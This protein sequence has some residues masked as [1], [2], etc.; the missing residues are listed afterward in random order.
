VR[1][2]RALQVGDG[3]RLVAEPRIGSADGGE[4]LGDLKPA[5]D[6]EIDAERRESERDGVLEPLEDEHG[7]RECVLRA[8]LLAARTAP[9]KRGD[10]F[11]VAFD[12]FL[13]ADR[14]AKQRRTRE[15]NLGLRAQRDVGHGHDA[16]GAIARGERALHVAELAQELALDRLRLD[17]ELG[18]FGRAGNVFGAFGVGKPAREEPLVEVEARRAHERE[19]HPLALAELLG[20]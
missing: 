17:F 14:S 6:L 3:A 19:G 20:E 5:A 7:E 2:A 8:S 12:G 11:G 18:G 10:R 16:Q 9:S 15:E 13:D 1:V 4:R